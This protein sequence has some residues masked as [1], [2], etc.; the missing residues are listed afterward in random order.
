MWSSRRQDTTAQS[1]TEAEYIACAETA[2]DL[3]WIQ[4]FLAEILPQS[5]IQCTVLTDNEAALKLTKTQ[6]FHRRTRHISHKYHY[7]REMVQEK[8]LTVLGIAGKE[9]PADIFTKI[10]PMVS[11]TNWKDKY[12][13]TG[14]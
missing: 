4:Q 11:V 14:L 2:K 12:M 3:R 6:T 7:I 1:I 8:H 9:N 10:I 13:G 5:I